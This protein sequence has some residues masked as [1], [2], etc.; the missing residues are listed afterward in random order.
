MSSQMLSQTHPVTVDLSQAPATVVEALRRIRGVEKHGHTFLDN[1]NK[2]TFFS[3]A[4]L[5]KAAEVRAHALL[6]QGLT[7]GDRV[8]MVLSQP[9]DF[10]ITFLGA[11]L[12]GLVPVPMFPP[13]SFGKLDAY[14]DSAVTILEVAGARLIITDKALSSVLWQ[15][16]PKVSTIKDLLL[17]E[18]LD[19]GKRSEGPLPD[20]TPDDLAFLQFTSGSTSAPKGVMVSHRSLVANCW[21]IATEGMGLELGSDVAISWLPLYHDMGLIGFVITPLFKATDVVYIPTLSFVK[22]PNV[23]LQTMHDYKGTLSFGPNFAFAL[24]TKR[25]SEKELATWD[26]SRVRLI[27]CGAEPINANVMLEFVERFAACGLKPGVPMPAYGMAEATL[28]MSFAPVGADLPVLLLDAEAFRGEG[29][30]VT[31]EDDA[32]AL[33]FVGCGKPFNQH[34]IA[35]IDLEGNLLGEDR[36][37][38]LVFAGPSLTDGYW[39]NEAATAEVYRP[40]TTA[41][42]AADPTIWLRTGDLGFVHDGNVFISGRSKDLIILNGRNH[43]PQSIEWAVAEIDGVRKG[44][45]VAFSRPGKESEELVVVVE[46]RS[47]PPADLKETIAK[48]V[49]DRLS[50]KVSDVIL[51][52]AGQLPKTSSGK[53]QRRKTREQYLAGQ[54]GGEGVRTLGTAGERLTVARHLARSLLGRATHAAS[55]VFNRPS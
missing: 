3:Y 51:L 7:R 25:A 6:G 24:A 31:P 41:D 42:G 44:N 2:P 39:K 52:A 8:A 26:L 11:L 1:A 29:K 48:T 38:E 18:S 40:L 35:V 32:L 50:L 53:L 43:H 34:R 9:Q 37:G 30:V 21:A 15:V 55:K 13:L 12:A 22:R 27:G 46:T 14:A 19:A 16:V 20:I 10:V 28:A 47:E 5:Y 45:V 54:L 36:E 33:A 4:A 17:V 23:W 49:A